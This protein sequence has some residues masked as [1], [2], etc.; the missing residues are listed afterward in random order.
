MNRHTRI[1]MLDTLRG[2]CVC[3]MIGYHGLWSAISLFGVS[4][5][6]FSG[7]VPH[8]IQQVFASLFIALAGFCWSLGHSPMKRGLEVFGLGC[9]LSVVTVLFLPSNAVIWGVLTLTGSAM[10]VLCWLAPLLQKTPA[11]LGLALSILLFILFRDLSDGFL[12]LGH[13]WSLTLPHG[14]YANYVTTFFGFPFSGFYSTDYFPF[15]SWFPMFLCGYFLYKLDFNL[16]TGRP[17]AFTAPLR[18][19]GR[20]ALGVYIVHQPIICGLLWL[21]FWVKN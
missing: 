18:F 13:Y 12:S 9:L 2:V 4:V 6:W 7:L 15:L 20:H 16:P 1:H 8:L 14:L 17:F 3:V 10:I 21:Y 19:L 11:I 5:P